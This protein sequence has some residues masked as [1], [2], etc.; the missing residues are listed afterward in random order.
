MGKTSHTRVLLHKSNSMPGWIPSQKTSECKC[1]QV[2]FSKTTIVTTRDSIVEYDNC[3]NTLKFMDF[4]CYS[5]QA[6]QPVM[7]QWQAAEMG[8]VA[9]SQAAWRRGGCWCGRSGVRSINLSFWVW[10]FVGTMICF[11]I[12]FGISLSS[13]NLV[14]GAR[15]GIDS[16]GK[17]RDDCRRFLAALLTYYLLHPVN[18][19]WRFILG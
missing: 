17:K 7:I 14:P 16:I 8:G 11:V 12:F 9:S 3:D 10:I 1:T 15:I 4:Q 2:R 5:V 18:C 19:Q 13:L 6:A